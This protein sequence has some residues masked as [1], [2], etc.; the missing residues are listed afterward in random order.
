[1]LRTMHWT[2]LLIVASLMAGCGAMQDATDQQMMKLKCCHEAKMAWLRCHDLYAE[3]C[4]PFDFGKG[5][6]SGYQAICMGAD[7]CR[8]AMPPRN[9]WGCQY[10]CEEGKC[11]IMAWYDGYHHGALAAACDGCE[12]RSKVLCAADL[13]AEAPHE[14]NYDD[15]A[16]NVI[17]Q[18][19]MAH[20]PYQP[21]PTGPMAVPPAPAVLDESA[22]PPVPEVVA[23]DPYGVP[24]APGSDYEVGAQAIPRGNDAP[25]KIQFDSGFDATEAPSF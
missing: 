6:R 25:G 2:G 19:Q 21:T 15:I 13:Y 12:G 8:P 20:D 4:Y 23:S 24:M 18:D 10:Q 1:M 3:V 14:M 11:Q 17:P 22:V 16:I 7:G 5:F 9:Y